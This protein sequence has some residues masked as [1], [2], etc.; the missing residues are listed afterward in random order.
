MW[1]GHEKAAFRFA[2][3]PDLTQTGVITSLYNWESL[4]YVSPTH[5]FT[6]AK[7]VVYFNGR[8]V[9]FHVVNSTELQVTLDAE[10]LREAGRFEF[11]VKNPEPLDPFFVRGMWGNGTSNVAHLIVNYKY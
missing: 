8:P 1:P 5:V 2:V 4:R 9:P 3:Y 6:D 7:S 11:V 10:A